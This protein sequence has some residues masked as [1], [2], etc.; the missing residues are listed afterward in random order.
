MEIL[1]IEFIFV[2]VKDTWLNCSVQIRNITLNAE[3]TE[4]VI[5]RSKYGNKLPNISTFEQVAKEL[6]LQIK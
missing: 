4:T 3:K 6:I 1:F 5:F 2:M